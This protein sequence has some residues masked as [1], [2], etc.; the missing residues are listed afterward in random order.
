M[1]V[2][3]AGINTSQP[4]MP[5]R[6]SYNH[7]LARKPQTYNAWL[8]EIAKGK[9]G[10]EIQPPRKPTQQQQQN[11]YKKKQCGYISPCHHV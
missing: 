3:I 6:F 5:K 7:F 10:N 2:Y 1:I 9:L 8:E 11:I 4:S